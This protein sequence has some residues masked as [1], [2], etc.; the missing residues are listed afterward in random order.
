MRKT[1]S[2][3]VIILFVSLFIYLFYRTEKTVVNELMILFLSFDTFAEIRSGITKA[4]PLNKAV[5]FSLPGGLWVFCTTVLAKDLYM[6]IGNH[7]IQLVLVPILFAVGLEFCQLIHITRGT[8]DLWDI[9]FYLVFWLL[10][11]G[12]FQP[13]N[14]QQNIMSSFTLR[15]YFCLVCFLSV[16]LAHVSQ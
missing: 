16:Y 1:Y 9:G 7:K 10:A 2:L 15:G 8:F 4:I 14:P 11:Y 12:G 5:I 13:R 3:V 6:K